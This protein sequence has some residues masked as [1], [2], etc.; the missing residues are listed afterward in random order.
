M[1][2]ALSR[3]A[4]R[5]FLA[6]VESLT[7]ESR[8]AAGK[9]TDEVEDALVRIGRHPLIGAERLELADPPVRFWTLQ[10]LPYLMVYDAVVSP[11]SI[12]R[13]FHGSRDLPELLG[14]LRA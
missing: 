12:L 10:R 1:K 6:V 11:P 7:S 13:I 3:A 8:R 2:A 5:D 9:F 14:D 4:T